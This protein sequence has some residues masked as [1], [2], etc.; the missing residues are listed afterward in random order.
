MRKINKEEYHNVDL[1]KRIIVFMICIIMVILFA[2]C[3]EEDETPHLTV[4]IDNT[5]KP[6]VDTSEIPQG[7]PAI[8]ETTETPMNTPI[9]TP[10]ETPEAT[11]AG[12]G[13]S[14]SGAMTGSSTGEDEEQQN[15]NLGRTFTMPR[16][17]TRVEQY[18]LWD[19][20]EY[21][22]PYVTIVY[23]YSNMAMYGLGIRSTPAEYQECR[24]GQSI[25][26]YISKGFIIGDYVGKTYDQARSMLG[27]GSSSFVKLLLGE[28][29][30]TVPEG[31]VISQNIPPGTLKTDQ[32]FVLKVFYSLGPDPSS[33]TPTPEP[34]AE[35]TP[36][37]T[38]EVTPEP[39]AEVTPEPTAEVTPEPTTEVTPEPTAETTAEPTTEPTAAPTAEPTVAPTP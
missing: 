30:D 18:I 4:I 6:T 21:A 15:V 8:E 11:D 23:E 7:I 39:T 9:V 5:E 10:L 32:D 26:I 37:P 27:I 17:W 12:S 2:G 20:P 13:T 31:V 38:A 1:L 24:E 16:V 29:S 25:T 22:R 36:E 34:T 33:V 28:Y 3:K 35:V 19:I 14:S